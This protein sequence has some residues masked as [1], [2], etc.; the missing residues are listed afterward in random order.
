MTEQALN[1]LTSNIKSSTSY[2]MLPVH[3]KTKAL[4]Y[5][6]AEGT[7]SIY[8]SYLFLFPYLTN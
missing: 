3:V 8:K 2:R 4:Y 6:I 1:G 5:V 7:I